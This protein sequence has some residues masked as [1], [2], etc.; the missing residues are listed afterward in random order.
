MRDP[1]GLGTAYV[2]LGTT[3]RRL[4]Y[5]LHLP[6]TPGASLARAA[7]IETHLLSSSKFQ[8]LGGSDREYN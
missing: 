3:G 8:T 7:S 1:L 2:C 6:V 5:A 4:A